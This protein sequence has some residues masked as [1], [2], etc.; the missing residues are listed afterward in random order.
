MRN[1]A[2]RTQSDY[3]LQQRRGRPPFALPVLANLAWIGGLPGLCD[4]EWSAGE[5]SLFDV[6]G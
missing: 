5:Q 4:L 1:D 6:R 3:S 2:F